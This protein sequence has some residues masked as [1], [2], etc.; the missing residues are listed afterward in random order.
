MK[1]SNTSTMNTNLTGASGYQL[2]TA[3]LF[4]AVL[5][6]LLS[7]PAFAGQKDPLTKKSAE[8]LLGPIMQGVKIDSVSKSPLQ[9]VWELVI[10]APN[11]E[12]SVVYFDDKKML[13]VTGSII[14]L[15]TRINLTQ[16]R[17]EDVNRVDFSSIPLD[18]ALVMGN[19]NAKYKVVVFDD[20]D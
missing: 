20:P 8:A 16:S 6:A 18:D 13:M 9:G 15:R 7:L 17:Y 1:R 3:L 19:R 2:L 14:D 10:A 5:L 4:S 12:K 11:G